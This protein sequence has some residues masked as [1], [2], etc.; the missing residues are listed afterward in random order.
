MTELQRNSYTQHIVGAKYSVQ[1]I[2]LYRYAMGENMLNKA[3]RDGNYLA[4]PHAS[5]WQR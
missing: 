2:R 5:A 1:I 4:P 3:I